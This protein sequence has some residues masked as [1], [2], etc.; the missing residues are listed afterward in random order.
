MNFVIKSFTFILE[1]HVLQLRILLLLYLIF[2]SGIYAQQPFV[3]EL[4]DSSGLPNGSVYDI[5]ED[6]SHIIW[7]ATNKGLIKYDGATFMPL[8]HE[9]QIGLSVFSLHK[10]VDGKVW[11]NNL[12]NQLFY[13]QKDS[14]PVLFGNYNQ[15]FKGENTNLLTHGNLIIISG[16]EDIA[17][18][19]SK[20]TEIKLSLQFTKKNNIT[21]FVRDNKLIVVCNPSEIS[22]IDLDTF[23]SSRHFY[24]QNEKGTYHFFGQQVAVSDDDLCFFNSS[25]GMHEAYVLKENH[26][27]RL[28]LLDNLI[29]DRLIKIVKI[30]ETLWF[31]TDN[32]LYKLS[33]DGQTLKLLDHYFEN[34]VITNIIKDTQENHWIST[35]DNGLFVAPDLSTTSIFKTNGEEISKV[36]PTNDGFSF[37]IDYH[38]VIGFDALQNRFDTI[39]HAPD[40]RIEFL[41]YN[42]FTKSHLY[43]KRNKI[44]QKKDHLLNEQF[45]NAVFKDLTF[46]NDSCLLIASNNY[47]AYSN[48]DKT[49][50]FFNRNKIIINGRS[51]STAYVP[52][53]KTKYFATID[54][55][56]AIDH[57]DVEKRITRNGEQ[58]YIKSLLANELY[59]VALTF[60]SGVYIIYDDGKILHLSTKNG[61]EEDLVDYAQ[62]LGDKV[63]FQTAKGVQIYDLSTDEFESIEVLSGRK[64]R[65]VRGMVLRDTTLYIATKNE[66][67]QLITLKTDR[68][69]VQ[70]PPYFTS[71]R[72]NDQSQEIQDELNLNS[73]SKK[74]EISFNT[75]G[76]LSSQK[77]AYEYQLNG[78]EWMPLNL[79]RS[80]IFNNL[81]S[82]DYSFRLRNSTGSQPLSLNFS[83][84]T[85][86]YKSVFFYLAIS[87]LIIALSGW[88]FEKKAK[89]IKQKEQI[90]LAQKQKE[91]ENIYLKIESLRSQMNP[92]FIFNALNAIQDYILKN[93]TKLARHYLVKFSK[94]IR[95]YLDHSQADEIN[96][97]EEIDALE[98]YLQL[99]QD[100]FKKAF[101]YTIKV[102]SEIDTSSIWLPTFLIQPYVEN[103]IKHGFVNQEGDKSITIAIQF[104][105]PH[106]IITIT[107][108]GIGRTRSE[109][110]KKNKRTYKSFATGAN[111]KRV[112]LL[113]SSSTYH[114]K[115]QIDDAFPA[116]PLPGTRV[117]INI[118]K[119]TA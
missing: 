39:A 81:E 17:I 97:K 11:Y 51:Y 27:K 96:L 80:V 111:K 47:A 45:A 62:I 76:F 92:H 75:N 19:D 66:I 40:E 10:D 26:F 57:D 6:D 78:S 21:P 7:L 32:G 43:Q 22:V 37:I 112:E 41:S 83:I 58:L 94:L 60:S 52:S 98:L 109:E 9:D 117:I 50:H 34:Q 70:L 91:L 1:I 73:D 85:P 104:H 74:I 119:I 93:E 67:F 64:N 87:A 42:P 88:H 3:I 35:L 107:D 63:W 113:N 15:I 23:E 114:I 13:V 18:I 72:V 102:D 99:E 61:L 65:D 53:T 115:I 24:S 116:Q 56:I 95:T 49:A 106:L 48:Y 5:I 86:F 46:I 84:A 103:A 33:Y 110:M 4:D 36:V 101:N 28:P 2:L 105:H 79:N 69:R 31:C 8:Y 71:V 54:G 16:Q 108:N 25:V 59:L 68:K 44:Y 29:F 55:L 89:T 82:G 20:T 100:R 118:Q 12:A 14:K 90:K 77:V 30:G 38:T